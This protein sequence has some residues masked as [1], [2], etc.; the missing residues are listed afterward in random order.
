MTFSQA[1]ELVLLAVSAAAPRRSG[2][3]FDAVVSFFKDGGP[4]MYVNVFW[5]ACSIAVIIERIVTLMF[6]YNLNAPPFMEQITKLVLTGNPD[7]AV[8]LCG[9]APNAPLAKV[10]R[11]GLTR[12]N[13]GELEVAKA[14][15]ESVL[16]HTPPVQTR[17]PWL[18]SLANIAT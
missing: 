6:R 8:K 18:W 15:E 16:E 13:R 2:N 17:I 5:L 11:A 12:A 9:A 14:V 4:F 10:I 1:H 7:R 3:M